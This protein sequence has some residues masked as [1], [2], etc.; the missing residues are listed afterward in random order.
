MNSIR[1]RQVAS[2]MICAKFNIRRV[3]K[4]LSICYK[5]FIINHPLI[6]KR[7]CKSKTI[8]LTFIQR[9]LVNKKDL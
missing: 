8:I 7:L 9:I 6:K 1:A 5:N 2:V 4:A 3:A